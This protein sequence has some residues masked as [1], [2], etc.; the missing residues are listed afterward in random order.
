MKLI[1]LTKDIPHQGLSVGDVISVDPR[2]ATALIKRGDADEYEPGADAAE[3][4]ET[5]DDIPSTAKRGRAVMSA[6]RVGSAD[7]GPGAI[8]VGE[9]M[10]PAEVQAD[11][12]AEAATDPP[13]KKAAAKQPPAASGAKPAG[14]DAGGGDT[15]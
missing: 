2:S 15:G 11:D 8:T 14:G 9:V 12:A 1:Q 5:I 3:K 4:V 7:P 6:V 13:P 10:P